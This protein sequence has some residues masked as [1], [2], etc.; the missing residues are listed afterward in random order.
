MLQKIL[1]TL[2]GNTLI[3]PYQVKSGLVRNGTGWEPYIQVLPSSE[4]SRFDL[5]GLT[6]D[7]FCTNIADMVNVRG[8]LSGVVENE[9]QLPVARWKIHQEDYRHALASCTLS[10]AQMVDLLSPLPSYVA[11]F[12]DEFIEFEAK[13]APQEGNDAVSGY[14][15]TVVTQDIGDRIAPYASYNLDTFFADAWQG[16]PPREED[17]EALRAILTVCLKAIGDAGVPIMQVYDATDYGY[18]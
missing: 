7:M 9:Q 8:R 2:Q 5:R 17:H 4:L 15:L 11:E 14:R 10:H 13:L 18:C 1:I 6:P 3:L 12:D 16:Y